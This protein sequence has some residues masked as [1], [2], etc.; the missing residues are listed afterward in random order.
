MPLNY[1][2][3]IH[4]IAQLFIILCF[5][6]YEMVG[7]QFPLKALW[8]TH[9]YSINPSELLED[10]KWNIHLGSRTQWTD[11]KGAPTL[12]D[13]DLQGSIAPHMGIGLQVRHE[14]IGL[15]K[16]NYLSASY[17]YTYIT[18][19]GALSV[20]ASGGISAWTID[21]AGIRTPSGNYDSGIEHHD[22]ILPVAKYT[23]FSPNYALG[24]AI[25]S[26]LGEIGMSFEKNSIA[27]WRLLDGGKYS[28]YGLYS[29]YW[30][31]WFK[32][33]D[34]ISLGPFLRYYGDKASSQVDLGTRMTLPGNISINAAFRINSWSAIDGIAVGVGYKWGADL[35]IYYVYDLTIGVNKRYWSGSG[36]EISIIYAWGGLR[37]GKKSPPIIFNPIYL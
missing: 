4:I 28:P 36:S 24:V 35:A 34:E 3:R 16:R 20:G 29:G 17:S 11:L 30:K 21:G 15:E 22:N 1:F 18:Q 8:Y 2:N 33:S 12:Y 23:S 9:P 27:G 6:R 37:K 19:M 10:A 26:V 14:S 13:L 7:Q 31:R 25:R 5:T 32:V